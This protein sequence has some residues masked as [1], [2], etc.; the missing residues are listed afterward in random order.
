MKKRSAGI[1]LF[2]FRKNL[3][4]I[5]LVHPGGPYFKNKDAASW[6]IPKG[7]IEEDE[8][9]LA[10]AIREFQEET[11]K[12][13]EGPF[14]PL[15]PVKQKSGKWV[16]AWAVE[17]DID[18]SCLTCNTFKIEWPPRSGKFS[19]FPEIDRGEWFTVDDAL[20]KILPAQAA[21]VRELAALNEDKKKADS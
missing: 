16:V 21:F 6:T 3:L 15:T 12:L 7:E 9:P 11:G 14:I 2:R 13:L 10:A 5:F 4:E 17:D 8:E 20:I 1:L 19:D 18:P